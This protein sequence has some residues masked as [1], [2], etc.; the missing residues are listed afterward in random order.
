[1]SLWIN[2]LDL[3]TLW[4]GKALK[5]KRME[6]T[7]FVSQIMLS[8]KHVT[9]SQSL[10]QFIFDLNYC[11]YQE[12]SWRLIFLHFERVL[13]IPNL[14]LLWMQ[15]KLFFALRQFLVLAGGCLCLVFL[16]LLFKWLQF[17]LFKK[18]KSESRSWEELSTVMKPFQ[19][20]QI[21]CLILSQSWLC[22][23]EGTLQKCVANYHLKSVLLLGKKESMKQNYTIGASYFLYFIA[24]LMHAHGFWAQ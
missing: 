8:L 17:L 24:T 6:A 16:Q 9:C 4:R 13:I 2:A 5:A 7:T 10:A 18:I 20:I 3:F 12:I 21:M 14:S 15:F 1:M 23:I 22:V 11:H 19:L